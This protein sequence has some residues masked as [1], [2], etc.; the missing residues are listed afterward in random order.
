MVFVFWK[1]RYEAFLEVLETV[2][3]RTLAEAMQEPGGWAT[4]AG[5]PEW[6]L[7]RFAH[8]DPAKS[9]SGLM[10]LVLMAY[11][12]AG[13]QR[14]LTLADITRADSRVAP[15][16]RARDHPARRHADREHRHLDGGDGPPRPLAVRLPGALREPGDRLHGGRDERWGTEGRAQVVYPEPNLWNEH[17]YYILDVPWSDGRQHEAAAEF[18]GF[19][20]S[21]PVQHRALEHGFRPGN[22]A[23][24][25]ESPESPLV[26]HQK[27][28]IKAAGS[29]E[30]H[31]RVRYSFMSPQLGVRSDQEIK[32][33]P[34]FF[35]SQPGRRFA[36]EPRRSTTLMLGFDVPVRLNATVVLPP[37]RA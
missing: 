13:K 19:L 30:G 23:V 15:G 16:V 29:S 28:G 9:N 11:E 21:E 8:T 35:R 1:D 25:V 14:G 32:L 3:F 4:I 17:P 34:T 37:R 2:N 27:Y 33:S 24:P 31:V 12:F 5:K 7:F 6:G 20:M 26:R 36:A 10:L 18:L 22:P